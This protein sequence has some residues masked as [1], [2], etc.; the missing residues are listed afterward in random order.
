MPSAIGFIKDQYTTLNL[1]IPPTNITESTYIVTGANT[2]LGYECTKHLLSMGVER[3]ILAV[4]TP[5][6]GEAALATLRRETGR[7]SAGEVWQ[8]DLTSLDSVEAFSKK[9]N[10]LNRLDALICNAG[11]IMSQFT[12]AEGLEMTLQVNV[13]ATALLALRA[14]P[15]LEESA[16]KF[17]TQPRLTIVSSDQSFGDNVKLCVEKLAPQGSVFAAFSE[18]KNFNSMAT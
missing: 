14:L 11:V 13:V 10:S 8:L 2:G 1:P 16:K 6:K 18:E 17:G 4:R 3:I 15:K 7:P 12:P 9:V 5:A